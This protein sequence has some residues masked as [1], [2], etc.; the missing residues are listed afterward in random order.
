M[1]PPTRVST[2]THGGNITNF[3]IEGE[4]VEKEEALDLP[5]GFLRSMPWRGFFI[6]RMNSAHETSGRISFETGSGNGKG[7]FQEANCFAW[8]KAEK[9]GR[10]NFSEITALY[11]NDFRKRDAVCLIEKERQSGTS[12]PGDLQQQNLRHK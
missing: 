4:G 10:I 12:L 5:F 1:Y 7:D 3:I 2:D 6:R 9:V 8:C 11:V